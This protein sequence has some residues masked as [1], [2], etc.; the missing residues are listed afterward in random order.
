[1]LVPLSCVGS[2]YL[3][4]Q[5]MTFT[6][7]KQEGLATRQELDDLVEE[8]FDKIKLLVENKRGYHVKQETDCELKPRVPVLFSV[9]VED[10][11][12]CC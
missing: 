2:A 4:W 3:K 11:S 12:Y 9:F 7:V 5:S 10:T 6:V 1:M 8:E